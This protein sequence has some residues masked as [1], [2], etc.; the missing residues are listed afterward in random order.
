MRQQ[1]K[2]LFDD[3]ERLVQSFETSRVQT[4]RTVP[5]VTEQKV[6]D[7][8]LRLKEVSGDNFLTKLVSGGEKYIAQARTDLWIQRMAT[9][10]LKSKEEMGDCSTVVRELTANYFAKIFSLCA[11]GFFI[12]VNNMGFGQNYTPQEGN[13]H[14]KNCANFVVN[15]TVYPTAIFESVRESMQAL[16]TSYHSLEYAAL[17]KN[18]KGITPELVSEHLAKIQQVA[19]QYLQANLVLT[20]TDEKKEDTFSPTLL[21]EMHHSVASSAFGTIRKTHVDYSTPLLDLYSH[22]YIT[23][24]PLNLKPLVPYTASKNVKKMYRLE[25]TYVPTDV[26]KVLDFFSTQQSLSDTRNG[27]T[28]LITVSLSDFEVLQRWHY[29]THM[30]NAELKCIVEPQDYTSLLDCSSLKSK[31]SQA[32]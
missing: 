21:P 3:L 2:Q 28:Q 15:T 5:P 31:Q 29:N 10:Q 26:E 16:H 8:A 1:E 11:K 23:V 20:L 12:D 22:T 17:S 7:Y 30:V 9:V 14:L 19:V 18:L 24:D 27:N 6:K 25:L 13:I 32:A 4:Y